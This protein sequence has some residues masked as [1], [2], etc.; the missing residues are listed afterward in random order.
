MWGKWRW[1]CVLAFGSEMKNNLQLA[2]WIIVP[3]MIV[4][5]QVVLNAYGA[6]D[7]A[8]GIWAFSVTSLVILLIWRHRLG[9]CIFSRPPVRSLNVEAMD[10]SDRR[11]VF[12]SGAAPFAVMIAIQLS[13]F[14][15][16]VIDPPL[17]HRHSGTLWT[18]FAIAAIGF[19]HISLYAS[20]WIV[21]HSTRWRRILKEHPIIPPHNNC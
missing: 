11:F 3:A 18:I 4:L 16:V 17:V 2:K 7:T 8:F 10:R 9:K 20:F 1:T 15:F 14:L 5:G 6:F 12:L 19:V 13:I 21:T